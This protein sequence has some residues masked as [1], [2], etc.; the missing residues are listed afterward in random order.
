MHQKHDVDRTLE[1]QK[2]VQIAEHT[3]R[4]KWMVEGYVYVLYKDCNFSH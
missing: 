4:C 1:G 3:T 2:R